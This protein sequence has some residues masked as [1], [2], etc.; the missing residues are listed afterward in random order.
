V[1][2]H[3][4]MSLRRVILRTLLQETE[5]IIMQLRW[6]YAYQS[7]RIERI[8]GIPGT[9]RFRSVSMVARRA[10]VVITLFRAENILTMR[11]KR[12][13]RHIWTRRVIDADWRHLRWQIQFG[14][15]VRL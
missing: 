3:R 11:E 14:G 6:L 13:V 2:D 10:C 12:S 4:D 9:R 1:R 7:E 5:I 8:I 15:G